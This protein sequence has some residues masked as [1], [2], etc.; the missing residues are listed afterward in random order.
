MTKDERQVKALP[1]LIGPKNAVAVTGFPWRWVRD[2]SAQLGVPSVGAG[3][4]RAVRAD[5]FVAALERAEVTT[6]PD[7]ANENTGDAAAA[8]RALIGKRLAGGAR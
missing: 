1:V 2:Q 5:L 8:V 7:A 4:K 6:Q 3:R